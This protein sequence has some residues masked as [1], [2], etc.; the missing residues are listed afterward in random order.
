MA[1]VTEFIEATNAKTTLMAR[2]GTGFHDEQ[3]S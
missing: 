2:V 1:T 3:Q